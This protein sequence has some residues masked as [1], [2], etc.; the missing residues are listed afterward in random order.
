MENRKVIQIVCSS[1]S[2]SFHP[3]S[4]TNEVGNRCNMLYAL[5]DDGTV[6]R[7][8]PHTGKWNRISDIPQD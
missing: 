2:H 8:G 1:S 3:D 4:K 7:L 6:W 5:C